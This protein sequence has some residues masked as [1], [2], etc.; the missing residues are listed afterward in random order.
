MWGRRGEVH[1]EVNGGAGGEMGKRHSESISKL[2]KIEHFSLPS[3]PLKGEK[4]RYTLA[5]QEP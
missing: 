5:Q 4:K 2:M 1:E 3:A